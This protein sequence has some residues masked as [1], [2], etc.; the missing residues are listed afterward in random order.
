MPIDAATFADRLR[1]LL[2]N[3]WFPDTAPVLDAIL[4]SLATPWAWLNQMLYYVTQQ[5]RVATAT[6]A[7]LDLAATDYLGTTLPRLPG[8]ADSSYRGR[9]GQSLLREAATRPAVISAIQESTGAVVTVFEPTKCSDTGAYGSIAN[10]L[11][12]LAYGVAGGWG[13]LNL[14][15]QFFMS[16][17]TTSQAGDPEPIGYG[18]SGGGYGAGSVEYCSLASIPGE[19]T[20]DDVRQLVLRLLPVN[21]TAWIR[22]S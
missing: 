14:P 15:Y 4:S 2:P 12:T 18:I 6:G 22:F 10:S 16:V 21:V 20:D 8:E 5:T 7:W 19:L 17:A 3:G 1:A 9:V 11:S 13:S